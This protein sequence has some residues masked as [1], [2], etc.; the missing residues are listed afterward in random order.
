MQFCGGWEFSRP[1]YRRI[2]AACR[3][4]VIELRPPANFALL[5]FFAID[6]LYR[7]IKPLLPP[8]RQRMT[9]DINFARPARD[10][11]RGQYLFC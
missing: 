9:L 5:Y 2:V 7:A 6:L 3:Q 1:G 8:F 11:L 10:G 4:F